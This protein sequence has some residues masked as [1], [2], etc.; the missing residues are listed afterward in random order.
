MYFIDNEE[1]CISRW[2]GRMMRDKTSLWFDQI[3]YER[4]RNDYK[5][6]RKDFNHYIQ[7]KEL[8]TTRKNTE[9][10]SV[11]ELEVIKE[12]ESKSPKATFERLKTIEEENEENSEENSEEISH[13]SL[14]VNTRKQSEDDYDLS[15]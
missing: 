1:E 11:P 9:V 14:Y 5:E 12:E 2:M 13:K 10:V 3:T 4:I 7:E 6:V 15:R 8:K